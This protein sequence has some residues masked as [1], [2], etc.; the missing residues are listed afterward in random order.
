[1][2]AVAARAAERWGDA[3]AGG[4]NG[5]SGVE[6]QD[7]A[8]PAHPLGPLVGAG[9]DADA[10]VP[11]GDPKPAWLRVKA[12]L[13]PRY[14]DV[15]RTMRS[16]ELVTVCEEAGCPNI[17]ECWGEGTATF[18]INGERCTRSCGFCLVD[19]RR[20]GP[21]D[22][23]EPERV[24][25]AVARMGLA[26][27]VVTA[28][29]RDDLPDGGAAAFADTITA[30]RRRCPHTAVEVLVPDFKGEPH[31]LAVVFEARP[32][33]LN[34]NLET[35]ARL[36][37]AVRPQASYARSL[38]VLARARTAGLTTKSGV[39]LG[40]GESEA[41]VL[42]AMADLRNVGVQILTLGQYLRPTARHLPVARWWAPDEFDRLAVAGTAM[43]FAHVEAS[44]LTRSSYHAR[45][46][47]EA[48]R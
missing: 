11:I 6:R 30:V 35:V 43:G 44:P 3:T 37:R 13:G 33:V 17:F 16:L 47:A 38:A 48:A 2:E 18:M 7:V 5:V 34:H 1:M 21:V 4:G 19:T 41:E 36:Q 12:D 32:D 10:A 20:P 42:G 45:R 46:A 24:A 22:G 25:E 23:A 29:A 27:A 40:M 28:V 8:G 14:R 26:H 9:V 15:R 39:I 31:A